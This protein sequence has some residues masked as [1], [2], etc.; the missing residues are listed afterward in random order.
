M[1]IGIS[2]TYQWA[3]HP[4]RKPIASPCNQLQ[5]QRQWTSEETEA[6]TQLSAKRTPHQ[7]PI[8]KEK[9]ENRNSD[10]VTSKNPRKTAIDLGIISLQEKDFRQMLLKMMQNI[11][12]KLEAKTDNL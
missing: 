12:N 5:P 2:H 6:T 10:K 9:A 8:R 4:I 1:R 7:K 11:G 3:V